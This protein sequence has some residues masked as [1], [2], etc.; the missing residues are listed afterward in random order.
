MNETTITSI[1]MIHCDIIGEFQTKSHH[2]LRRSKGMELTTI[3]NQPNHLGISGEP[4]V[5]LQKILVP[6]DM[7]HAAVEWSK[8]EGHN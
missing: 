5:D 3:S 2:Q 1:Q 8:R 6:F 7:L 4:S